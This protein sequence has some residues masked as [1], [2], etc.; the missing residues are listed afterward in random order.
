M[1]PGSRPQNSAFFPEEAEL[2]AQT[3]A[4]IQQEAERIAANCRIS[5]AF[6]FVD[7]GF[8]ELLRA[9]W[10]LYFQGQ[11]LP[12]L[13]WWQQ[14]TGSGADGDLERWRT[15]RTDLELAWRDYRR[16]KPGAAW[17]LAAVLAGMAQALTQARDRVNALLSDARPGAWPLQASAA[18]PPAPLPTWA[19]LTPARELVAKMGQKRCCHHA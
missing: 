11:L 7:E 14:V 9:F 8:L 17:Q 16:E 6:A 15:L 2:L 10:D 12:R 19:D 4:L 13:L 3:G 18:L 1:P 5:E